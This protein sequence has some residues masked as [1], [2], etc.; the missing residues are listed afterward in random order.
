MKRLIFFLA[1]TAIIMWHLLLCA[2]TPTVV[3]FDEQNCRSFVTNNINP[4]TD[5]MTIRIHEPVSQNS[6]DDEV[7]LASFKS[8]FEFG[9]SVVAENRANRIAHENFDLYAMVFPYTVSLEGL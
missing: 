3:C 4:L 5:H 6:D 8:G 7:F 1:P 9:F 2:M